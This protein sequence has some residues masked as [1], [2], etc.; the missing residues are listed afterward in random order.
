MYQVGIAVAIQLSS[1]FQGVNSPVFC[2]LVPNTW[3][4]NRDTAF[5]I[6]A[7]P[8]A[9]SAFVQRFER[10]GRSI[11][12]YGQRF[13]VLAAGS[14]LA[15]L[16]APGDSVVAV[17]WTT[18][19]D[20]HS[21]PT[22]QALFAPAGVET[23]M[24]GSLR[25]APA[26]RTPGVLHIIPLK[27][28][29]VYSPMA[30]PPWCGPALTAAEYAEVYAALPTPEKWFGDRVAAADAFDRWLDQRPALQG[31]WPVTFMRERLRSGDR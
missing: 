25:T 17:S 14:G 8:L 28:H 24:Q 3:L 11:D 16:L 12:V 15:E 6:V 10:Y 21:Y 13:N 27:R 22:G 20:C 23:Y 5:Y 9:D 26:S 1:L 18:T 7:L 4:S 30:Q 31:R 29:R 19:S 2:S